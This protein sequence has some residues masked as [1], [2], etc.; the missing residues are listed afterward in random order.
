MLSEFNYHRPESLDDA[1]ELINT[2]VDGLFLAGGQTILPLMKH[3][4]ATPTDIIDLASIEELKGI[5]VNDESIT[6]G[7]MTSHTTVAKSQIVRDNFL[8]L[9]ELAGAIGDPHIR[10]KGTIGGSIAYNDPAA[11]YPAALL[12]LGATVFTNKREIS[13]D[14]FFVDIFETALEEG[15]LIIRIDFPFVDCTAYEK[16]ANPASLFAL[17][18]VMVSRND[19]IVRVAVTGAG[20]S[21]FRINQIEKALEASFTAASLD[22][23]PIKHADLNTDLHASA[24]YRAHLI[25][26]LA[27]RAVRKAANQLDQKAPHL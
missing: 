24:E 3:N 6:I 15:E 8:S 7:A 19:S 18:G 20:P 17:V 13:A 21:V 2:T 10:N 1:I 27:A 14:D 25:K 16:F 11:D 9:A 22:E 26:V 23:V 5:S 12:G 4:L